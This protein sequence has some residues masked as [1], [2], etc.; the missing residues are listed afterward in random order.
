MHRG[1]ISTF[2]ET[3]RSLNRGFEN[4]G[5]ISDSLAIIARTIANAIR[6]DDEEREGPRTDSV[7]AVAAARRYRNALISR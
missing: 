3:S 1:Y 5:E 2:R 7:I 4:R 6:T